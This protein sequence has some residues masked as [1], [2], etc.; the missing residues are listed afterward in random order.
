MAVTAQGSG[1]WTDLKGATFTATNGTDTF[2]KN[3]HGLVAGDRIQVQNSGGGLPAGMSAAT[4]YYV[5]S[6]GLT[7]NDFKVSTTEGGGTINITTDGTGTQSFSFVE[8]IV[9]DVAAAGTYTLH[10]DTNAM[11][12]GDVLELRIY[13]MVLTG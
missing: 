9:A 2:T 8:H 10:V 12:A 5:I 6:S 7:T 11:A 1:T 3:S 4:D 13:Q